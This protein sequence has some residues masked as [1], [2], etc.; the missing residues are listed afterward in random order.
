MEFS[1]LSSAQKILY[2]LRQ[3]LFDHIQKLP[4]NFFS[5][6]SVGKINV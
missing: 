4:V 5:K 1:L 6:N 3:D 2:Q